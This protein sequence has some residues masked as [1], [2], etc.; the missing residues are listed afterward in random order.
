MPWSMV[1]GGSSGCLRPDGPAVSGEKGGGG[2]N[3]RAGKLIGLAEKVES[4]ISDETICRHLGATSAA[5]GPGSSAVT[6]A[7]QCTRHVLGIEMAA[8]KRRSG[9]HDLLH[10][11]GDRFDG[12]EVFGVQQRRRNHD[13]EFSLHGD[14]EVDQVERRQADINQSIRGAEVGVDG[15][16]FRDFL[17]KTQCSIGYGFCSDPG[18]VASAPFESGILM[19][20]SCHERGSSRTSDV[21]GADARPVHDTANRTRGDAKGLG[22]FDGYH[23]FEF[24]DQSINRC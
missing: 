17:G 19:H 20:P 23:S 14:H 16:T 8:T 22:S 15:V 13:V 7:G 4:W 5:S 21:P 12:V 2:R 3:V 9:D 6:G 24:E 10:H 18:H 11:V 1:A